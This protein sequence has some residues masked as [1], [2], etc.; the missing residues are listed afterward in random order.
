MLAPEQHAQ[1]ERREGIRRN[2]AA[3]LWLEEPVVP[4]VTDYQQKF[5]DRELHQDYAENQQN[6][7]ASRKAFR[8]IDPEL[9]NRGRQNEQC[10]HKIL[11]RFRLLT[12]ENKKRQTANKHREN[13]QLAVRCVFQTAS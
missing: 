2:Q 11:C 12:A 7:R 5:R 13:Q 4:A 1:H 10:N 9:S 3:H 6:P 8:L